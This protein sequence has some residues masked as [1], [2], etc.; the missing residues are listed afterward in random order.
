M[1]YSVVDDKNQLHWKRGTDTGPNGLF[2][3][4]PISATSH[5]VPILSWFLG[6]FLCSVS[7]WNLRV[8]FLSSFRETVGTAQAHNEIRESTFTQGHLRHRDIQN[9]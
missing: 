2:D 3:C 1:C 4:S 5:F 7:E 9:M 6:L 8:I